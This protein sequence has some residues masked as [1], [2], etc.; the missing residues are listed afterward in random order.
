MQVTHA[1]VIAACQTE[2]DDRAKRFRKGGS[3]DDW[4]HLLRAMLVL[5]Q[6]RQIQPIHE[7]EEFAAHLGTIPMGE[8]GEAIVK[9]VTGRSIAQVLAERP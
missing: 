1:R 7:R 9:R 8:W 2:F 4:T 5:Q 3:A 6:A